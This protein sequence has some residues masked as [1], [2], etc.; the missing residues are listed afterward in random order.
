M[1]VK[2]K[3][4]PKPIKPEPYDLVSL[5][6]SR[7]DEK[8]SSYN[9]KITGWWTGASWWG[10]RLRSGDKVLNWEKDKDSHG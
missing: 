9:K 3:S 1:D 6:I 8:G 5:F 10:F 4:N 2:K 7:K